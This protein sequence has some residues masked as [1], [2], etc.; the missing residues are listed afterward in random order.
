MATAGP[1]TIVKVQRRTS[2]SPN[3]WNKELHLP[4][5]HGMMVVAP[6][7]FTDPLLELYYEH[8]HN[9]HPCVLPYAFLRHKLVDAAPGRNLLIS[10]MRFIGS[11]YAPTTPSKDLDNDVKLAIAQ[12]QPW[13][14]P[15][16]IQGLALY[17]T[18][19]YWWS[20]RPRSKQLLDQAATK[21]IT[22]GMNLKQYAAENSGGDHVLAESWRR[23]WWQVY[24]TDI[25][26]N[27]ET[28]LRTSQQSS[29]M[30]VDLPCEENEY[31]SGVCRPSRVGQVC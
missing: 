21:A 10:V 3:F 15:F 1:Q 4:A 5:R 16:E 18:A 29:V 8:F 6:P 13:T 28:N 30:T 14:H 31:C 19:T 11:L 25:R 2:N 9:S 20:D 17:A 26:I 22:I 23:T 12:P 24:I 27:A 7:L